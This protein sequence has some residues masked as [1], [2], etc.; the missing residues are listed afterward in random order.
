MKPSVEEYQTCHDVLVR[1]GMTTFGDYVRYCNNCDVIG[2]VEAVERMVANEKNNR[3]D[4]FNDSVSLPGLRENIVGEPSIIFHRYQEREETL[5]KGK[6][7]CKTVKGFDA[8]SLYFSYLGQLMPTG[9]Y[10]VQE[11][12]ND[13]RKER[14]SQECFQWLDYVIRTTGAQIRHAKN[15]GEV[16]IANFSVDGYDESTLNGVMNTTHAFGTTIFEK[17]ATLLR[18][19]TK[20]W[21]MRT[22]YENS[23]TILSPSPAASG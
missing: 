3:L 4:I 17:Q 10:P 1:E 12:R 2:F 15:G 6:Y 19:G 20:H 22:R 18:Y 5:I 21:S 14:Y 9:Y 23:P 13:Y 11:E 7:P 16:R 8:N